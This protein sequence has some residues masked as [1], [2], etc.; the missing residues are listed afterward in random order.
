MRPMI[1]A[2][3]AGGLLVA[4]SAMAQDRGGDMMRGGMARGEFGGGMRDGM[5]GG[6]ERGEFGGDMRDGMRGGM[7]R[8]GMGMMGRFSPEDIEAFTDARIAAMHAGLK[9][10]ADQEGMWPPV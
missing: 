8:R 9:L 10:S 6:M 2:I 4:G 3:A 7:D 5:R 1:V